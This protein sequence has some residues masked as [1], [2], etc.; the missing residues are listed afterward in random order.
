[1]NLCIYLPS[2]SVFRGHVYLRFIKYI[3]ETEVPYPILKGE[4]YT[5]DVPE[6]KFV[7]YIFSTPFSLKCHP[8]GLFTIESVH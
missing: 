1:M 4:D 3:Q 2:L 6:R 7:C 5:T 8:F